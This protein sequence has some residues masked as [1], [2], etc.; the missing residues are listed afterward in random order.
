MINKLTD[1][2]VYSLANNCP[3]LQHLNL[4]SGKFVTDDSLIYLA[5]KCVQLLTLNVSE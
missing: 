2:V 1:S 4:S 5:Q 3:F